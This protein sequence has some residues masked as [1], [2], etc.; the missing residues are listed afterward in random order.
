MMPPSAVRSSGLLVGVAVLVI[1]TAVAGVVTLL[2][3]PPEQTQA[4]HHALSQYTARR[5]AA[6]DP[7]LLL[8]RTPPMAVPAL[9]PT[10]DARVRP[11][12]RVIGVTVGGR[13]RAYAL[14]AFADVGT[15]V[16][17]D[18]LGGRPLAVTHCPRT[19]CT[20][21]FTSVDGKPL[22]LGVGGWFRKEGEEEMV[23]RIEY[24]HYRQST[25]EG[26]AGGSSIPFSS[27]DYE[28]TSWDEWRKKYPDTDVYAG[29]AVAT[30]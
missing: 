22:R 29:G 17:N 19:G 7:N 10:A 26:V 5:A 23:L 27:L 21:V 9:L 1:A 25:G 16:V 18:L 14:A 28:L 8:V 4:A 11:D 3:L 2:L 30:Y 15:H 13:H 6:D 20:R 24:Q 12:D